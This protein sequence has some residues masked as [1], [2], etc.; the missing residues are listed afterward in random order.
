MREYRKFSRDEGTICYHLVFEKD[1][2]V[3]VFNKGYDDTTYR[4]T[5]YRKLTE[6]RFSILNERVWT[7]AIGKALEIIDVI[8]N[9]EI[10]PR[11]DILGSILRGAD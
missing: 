4:H 3:I 9:V 1:E 10:D 6:D 8:D 2:Y 5:E 7:F 11:G